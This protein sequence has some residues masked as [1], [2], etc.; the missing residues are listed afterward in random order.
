M[1]AV[2]ARIAKRGVEE[3]GLSLAEIARKVGVRT[4]SVART[5]ARISKGRVGVTEII[6]KV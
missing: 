5:I 6:N 4:S 2:R 1:S 3:L